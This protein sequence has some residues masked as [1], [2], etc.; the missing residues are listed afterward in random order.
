M[1][2]VRDESNPH[3]V[4]DHESDVEFVG[5]EEGDVIQEIRFTEKVERKSSS[6]TGIDI[7]VQ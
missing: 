3:I 7:I 6:D 5:E 4:S 2:L 1:V